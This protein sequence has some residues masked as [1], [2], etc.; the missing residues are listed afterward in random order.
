MCKKIAILSFVLILLLPGATLVLADDS[1]EDADY[2]WRGHE[3]PFD[4]TFGNMIDS[5]QQ[6]N[7]D[8]SG[9][10][11]GFLYIHDTGETE[12]GYPVAERADCPSQVCNVGWVLKGVPISAKL[13]HKGPRVWLVDPADLPSEPGYTHFQWVGDPPSPH[14]LEVGKVYEGIVLKRVAPAPFHWLGG[15]GSGGGGG[16]GGGDPGG[17]DGGCSGGGDT[18]GCDGG[19][20][21]DT[22]GCTGDD[23]GGC[24]DDTGGC[25]G[26]DTGGCTGDTGGCTGDETGGCTGDET[27]GCSDGGDTGGCDGGCTGGGSSGGEPGGCGGGCSGGGGGGGHGGRLVPEGV[28][29]H[30]NIVTS[31][32][33]TGSGGGCGGREGGGG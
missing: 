18:G 12:E 25:T 30:S 16:S 29:P 21:D 15:S 8:G 24:A 17:C 13:V 11:Q 14:G 22:G 19:C 7:R 26:D 3:P 27:G 2:P 9:K 4:F 1:D 5:H 6:S 32:D 20:T 31:W 23:T 33:G 10:L 28:D